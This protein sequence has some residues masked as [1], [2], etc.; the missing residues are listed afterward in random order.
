MPQHILFVLPT[1]FLGGAERVVFNLAY[2]LAR[3]PNTRITIYIMSRG[4]QAGWD[5]LEHSS[6]VRFIFKQYASEKTSAPAFMYEVSRLSRQTTFSHVFS[7]HTHINAMLSLLRKLGHLKTDYLVSRESTVVFERF[8]RK[9]KLILHVIYRLMYGAQD[10]VICQTENM[11][12]SLLHHLP[13]SPAR[14]LAVIPNPVNLDYIDK[15]RSAGLP[16]NKPFKTLIVC[17]G[18]LIALKQFDLLIEAFGQLNTDYPDAGLVII[19]EGP[20][21][22]ALEQ[23]VK[24]LEISSQVIFTGQVQNPVAWFAQADLG[25]ICSS[26]EGFPNVIIEMMASGTKQIISTPCTDG[27]YQLPSIC[28]TTDIS[29][30]AIQLALAGQLA[31]PQNNYHIYRHYIEQFRSVSSFWYNMHEYLHS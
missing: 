6:N 28:I 21:K 20:E 24:Q 9:L 13:R 7:T 17:C 10:L 14:Q 29:S 3:Q 2:W 23:Q 30:S 19:G 25:V 18:R 22:P 31:Q 15:Q 16:D 5:L 8:T 4:R 26:R 27:V 11:Q 12:H 1:A